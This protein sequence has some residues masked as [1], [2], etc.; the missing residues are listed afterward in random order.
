MT[1]D[2]ISLLHND[3]V[4]STST[5][6]NDV[7][8]TSTPGRIVVKF[9][10][11]F[12]YRECALMG[13]QQCD[14][15]QCICVTIVYWILFCKPCQKAIVVAFPELIFLI[16]S[17]AVVC[18]YELMPVT[19]TFRNCKGQYWHVKVEVNECN[20][21]MFFKKG[22]RK[23][24][25]ENSVKDKDI[26]FF[27]CFGC[28]VFDVKVFRLDRCEKSVSHLVLDEQED[29]DYDDDD[30]DE[31]FQEEGEDSEMELE[32]EAEEEN[33]YDDFQEERKDSE[34]ELEEEENDDEDYHE[35]GEDKE[36]ELVEEEENEEVLD[37]LN[38]RRGQKMNN[39]RNE[40]DLFFVCECICACM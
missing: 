19:V 24:I 25:D 18:S 23:F 34:L 26:L 33:D 35:E 12:V 7:S 1:C 40:G 30:D 32:E 38:K 36:Q 16:P 29:D 10:V 8:S 6:N 39:K 21:Q 31:E 27:S 15:I 3:H 9:S 14:E 11:L 22:W 20:G 5:C 4:L 2:V 17:T 28:F 37:S 13:F